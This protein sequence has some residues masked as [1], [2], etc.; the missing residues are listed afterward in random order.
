[1]KSILITIAL[2]WPRIGTPD[3]Y[4]GNW[5]AI[6]CNDFFPSVGKPLL[7]WKEGPYLLPMPPAIEGYVW[8]S[9]QHNGEWLWW[10]YKAAPPLAQ[11]EVKE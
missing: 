6:D 2:L 10:L 4:T 3:V 8:H 7:S 9:E 11:D 1:M 5:S